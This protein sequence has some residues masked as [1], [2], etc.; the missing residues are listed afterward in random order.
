MNASHYRSTIVIFNFVL[1]LRGVGDAQNSHLF[2]R[3]AL[4]FFVRCLKGHS[5]IAIEEYD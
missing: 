1:K 4:L 2:R 5:W 3:Y